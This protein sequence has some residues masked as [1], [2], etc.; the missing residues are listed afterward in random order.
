M[1]R[2]RGMGVLALL[3]VLTSL[4]AASLAQAAPQPEMNY[5]LRHVISVMRGNG[6][7]PERAPDGKTVAWIRTARFPVFIEEEPFPT[8]PNALHFTTTEPTVLR[9]VLLKPGMVWDRKLAEE[10]ARNLRGLAI[11][12]VVAVVPVRA[13]DPQQIGLVVVTRDLW[14]LR[15]E[16]RFQL[17]GSFI[18]TLMVQLTE[19]NLL[20]RDKRASLRFNLEPLDYA[21]GAVYV[22][23][24]LLGEKLRLVTTVDAH[25]E[26]SSDDYD[27]LSGYVELGRPLYDLQQRWGFGLVA[28]YQQYTERQAQRGGLL[29]FTEPDCEGGDPEADCLSAGRIWDHR[30][31]GTAALGRVQWGKGWIVRAAGGLGFLRVDADPNDA[32]GLPAGDDARTVAFRAAFADTVLPRE[33]QWVY[34]TANVRFF[35]NRHQVF[36]DLAGFGLSEDVQLGPEVFFDVRAP[37]ESIGSSESLVD[38]GGSLAWREAWGGDGLIELAGGVR[39]RLWLSDGDDGQAAGEWFDIRTLARVRGST[40]RLG[41]GRVVLR[42]DW[43]TQREQL[44]PGLVTLGGDNGLRGYPSQHL[45]AF[46]ADRLRG[47]LEYRTPPWVVSFLHL[48][49]VAFFDIGTVY[50][51]INDAPLL[52]AAGLGLRMVVPQ[53]SSFAYRLDLGVPTDGS[54]G[55]F[56]KLGFET[57]QAVPVTPK[58][59]RLYEFS[60]GGLANQ[61]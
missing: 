13:E 47:N 23:P 1:R 15:T 16:T 58:E 2:A 38:M 50:D 44:T 18:D 5:E 3:L 36:R 21:L 22:D 37:L 17:T 61:P 24:R 53:A 14:S 6:L 33:R 55:F 42:G 59:D 45:F 28:Q 43:V 9:E 30:F 31:V 10:T 49:A 56:V 46:G 60:V 39:A 8:W 48:G 12:N 52:H 25:F 11:F 27:G 34:P 32:T 51:D 35:E 57:N 20:G 19:R 29:A 7:I 54:D 41:F 40:P 4:P 26:R